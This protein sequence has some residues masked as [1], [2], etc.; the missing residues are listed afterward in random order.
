MKNDGRFLK[1]KYQKGESA[2][3]SAISW[4]KHDGTSKTE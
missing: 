3:N 4:L 1:K 2:I